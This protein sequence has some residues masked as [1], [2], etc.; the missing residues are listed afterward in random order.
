MELPSP[1]EEDSSSTLEDSS[2][3][4]DDCARFLAA[5]IGLEAAFT[6]TVFLPA[7]AALLF[8][9]AALPVASSLEDESSS[10][11]LEDSS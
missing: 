10:S 3:L 11:P 5:A 8:R 1:S 6:G 4:D 9:L 7:A 2:S